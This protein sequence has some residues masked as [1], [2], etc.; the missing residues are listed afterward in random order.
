MKNQPE[1][2]F[3]NELPIRLG[4]FLKLA[5]LAQDGLEARTIIQEGRIL[6]NGTVEKKRGKKLFSGDT[7]TFGEK[8]WVVVA[9]G[10]R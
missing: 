2:V 10:N 3:V 5:D 6:V 9:G 4:Q 7:V 8:D 1:N